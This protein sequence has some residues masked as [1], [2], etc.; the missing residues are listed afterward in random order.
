MLR[1]ICESPRCMRCLT[2][3][4]RELD[5]LIRPENQAGL[6]SGLARVR[7]TKSLTSGGSVV[8]GSPAKSCQMPGNQTSF[9]A[10][11]AGRVFVKHVRRRQARVHLYEP[12]FS[13]PQDEVDT[14]NTFET[15]VM[16]Q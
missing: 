16:N 3:W 7:I 2:T 10:V 4:V 13:L 1:D 14:E 11:T 8:C 5:V 9:F 15:R 6:N 12:G